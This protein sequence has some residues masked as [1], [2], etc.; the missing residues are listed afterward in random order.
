METNFEEEVSELNRIELQ[1][2]KDKL[3]R[4]KKFVDHKILY[5]NKQNQMIRHMERKIMNRSKE[6]L[7]KCDI[8]GKKPNKETEDRLRTLPDKR[9]V[10]K[11]CWLKECKQIQINN[12]INYFKSNGFAILPASEGRIEGLPGLTTPALQ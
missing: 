10:C 6:L 8:C 9:L 3:A 7:E 11:P 1:D 5:W 12:Y 4:D 2:R